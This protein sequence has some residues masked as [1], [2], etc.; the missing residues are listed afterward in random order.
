M[1]DCSLLDFARKIVYEHQRENSDESILVIPAVHDAIDLDH[2]SIE[3]IAARYDG[4]YIRCDDS[5]TPLYEAHGPINE[6]MAQYLIQLCAS[7]NLSISISER[8]G[9]VIAVSDEKGEATGA[10]PM[11]LRVLAALASAD[12]DKS[13]VILSYSLNGLD[14]VRAALLWEVTLAPGY[15]APPLLRTFVPVAAGDVDVAR[16]CNRTEG[17]VRLVVRDGELIERGASILLSDSLPMILSDINDPIVLFLG[18]GASASC[19]MPQGNYL[20]DQ[21]LASL[22][23]RPLGS[24]ELVP[25][26]RRWLTNHDRWLVDESSLP[27]DVFERNLTLE[28][29]LR[30]EFYSL[31]GKPRDKSVTVQRLASYCRRALDR[32]PEGRKAF[33]KLAEIL[34]RLVIATVNFDQ[35]IEI[36]IGVDKCVIVGKDEFAKH[37]DLVINRVSGVGGRVPIL[38]LHGSIDDP[39]S[40]V[41][42]ITATT[43]GLPAEMVGTLDAVLEASGY[44]TWVWIGCSMRDADIGAW[45]AGKSGI[46]DMQEWWVDPLPPR[47]VSAYAEMNRLMEWAQIPQKLRDRQITETSDRFLS[48]L[49]VHAA[50]LEKGLE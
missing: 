1:R 37:R 19:N 30:E 10:L 17:A 38:K 43:R 6:T 50:R 5:A 33:W 18:A 47:S 26:F 40:L 14:E 7:R 36:G 9:R 32:L 16:H 39:G 34:P 20:R 25:S 22:T 35:L 41:A 15:F 3:A 2:T 44:L 48:A 31:G 28:R 42:D 46:K 21:A 27:A 8:D 4:E 45:L 24:A 11:I 29:V 49:A 23:Q 13:L 12:L